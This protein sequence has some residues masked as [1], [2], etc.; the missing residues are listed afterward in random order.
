MP[1]LPTWYVGREPVG[2]FLAARVLRQPGDLRMIPAAANG[3]PAFAAYL[4]GNDG[5]YRAHA[6]QVLT[7][8][9][10]GLSRVV[11]F[12]DSGLFATFGLPESLRTISAR[13]G[14]V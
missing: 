4:R 9:P 1:P 12:I 6:V 10:S 8:T 11:S 5:V 13:P 7:V 2:R 3:Q 14:D